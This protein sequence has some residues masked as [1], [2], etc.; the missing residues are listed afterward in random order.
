MPDYLR[1]ETRL[2]A[3]IAS[4]TQALHLGL[5]TGAALLRATSLNTTPDGTPI[6]RGQTW[7]A[8]T[9]VTLLI[10]PD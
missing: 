4:P 9:R 3:V 6:E 7:F 10:A 1:A 8:S 2:N 5:P